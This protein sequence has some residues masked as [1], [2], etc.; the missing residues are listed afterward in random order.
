VLLA[1][2]AWQ[3]AHDNEQLVLLVSRSSS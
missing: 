1:G 3:F 2:A